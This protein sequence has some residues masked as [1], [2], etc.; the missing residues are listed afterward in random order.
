MAS[1]I[2]PEREIEKIFVSEI[3]RVGG[4]AYKFVSPGNSGV[5]D[6]IVILPYGRILF[7]ELKTACGSLT[8]LQ[9]AQCHKIANLGAKVYVLYGLK[10]L[11]V[12]FDYYRMPESAKRVKMRI[13]RGKK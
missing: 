8:K 11:C 2:I 9:Q 5:P 7:V 13:L 1:E 6:R 4:V 10:D 12:F 3:N